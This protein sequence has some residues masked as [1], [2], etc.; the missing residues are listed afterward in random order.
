[1]PRSRLQRQDV[2]MQFF[3]ADLKTDAANSG[4]LEE[5]EYETNLSIDSYY[6]WA[7]HKIETTYANM[8]ACAADNC[9]KLALSTRQGAA[10]FPALTDAG[11][12]MFCGIGLI[13]QTS[14]VSF[15][16]LPNIQDWLPPI[17]LAASKI[18]A[19]AESIADDAAL[20]DQTIPCR[21]NY[22]TVPLDEKNFIEIAQTW[23][24]TI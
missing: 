9:L 18:S 22:T 8:R 7:I 20:Q 3:K 13:Y 23:G 21:I 24:A 14:G 11:T 16:M 1:M 15:Y 19:Y 2:F 5:V 12:I 17:I 6:A 4:N 10:S